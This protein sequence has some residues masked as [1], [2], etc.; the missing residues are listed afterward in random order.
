MSTEILGTRERR[1]PDRKVGPWTLRLTY[2]VVDGRP[3]VLGVELYAVDP[4]RIAEAAAGW[5]KVD[6]RPARKTRRITTAGMR[7]PLADLLVEYLSQNQRA[8]DLIANADP[9][10]LEQ[11][12]GHL[13]LSAETM[14]TVASKRVRVIG[15]TRPPRRRG[16]PPRSADAT[17]T[18]Y[19]EAARIYNEALASRLAPLDAITEEMHVGRSTAGKYVARAR[20]AGLL[21]P[22]TPGKA[23][24]FPIQKSRARSASKREQTR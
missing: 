18:L 17:R 9:R 14:R 16:R 12:A 11:A 7:V 19:E 10:W 21:P 3:G 23:R 20:A 13:G 5:P 1:W 2:G 24:G 15:E 8:D 6:V 4:E 22:T